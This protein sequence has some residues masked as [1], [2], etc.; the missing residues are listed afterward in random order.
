M[1]KQLGRSASWQQCSRPEPFVM[2]ALIEQSLYFLNPIF[3]ASSHLLQPFSLACVGPG[4]KPW[5][6]FSCDTAHIESF[7]KIIIKYS[8]Y[9]DCCKFQCE[10]KAECSR[11]ITEVNRLVLSTQKTQPYT[12]VSKILISVKC[13]F[14]KIMSAKLKK[15]KTKKKHF[16]IVC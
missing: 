6:Q 3:Q 14:N 9:L 1:Q 5:R 12:Q 7:L 8:P 4:W 15:S 11:W 13:K 10:T 2:G 16:Q